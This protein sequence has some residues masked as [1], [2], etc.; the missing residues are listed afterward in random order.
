MTRLSR[1]PRVSFDKDWFESMLKLNGYTKTQIADRLSIKSSTIST[2]LNSTRPLK[3]SEATIL[4][5]LFATPLDEVYHRAGLNDEGE[6]PPPAERVY[7]KT[8]DTVRVVNIDHSVPSQEPTVRITKPRA[9]FERTEAIQIVMQL[10]ASLDYPKG[11]GGGAV[12]SFPIEQLEIIVC[13]IA[14]LQF[15]Q[16]I[17]DILSMHKE[18]PESTITDIVKL[19]QEQVNA[20][21]NISTVLNEWKE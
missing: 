18:H 1:R 7:K 16:D 3:K 20:K 9:F 12:F 10:G 11:L 14:T 15:N 2:I 19:L 17:A 5:E 13:S 4:S 21:K 8:V 6:P